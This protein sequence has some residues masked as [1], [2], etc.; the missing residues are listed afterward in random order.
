MKR[1]LCASASAVVSNDGP[2]TVTTLSDEQ[3]FSSGFPQWKSTK[4]LA[5]VGNIP[6]LFIALDYISKEEECA[7][8]AAIDKCEW[9]DDLRRRVLSK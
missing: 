5:E 3:E 4:T 6:G 9:K 2:E 7:M 8:V 1:K